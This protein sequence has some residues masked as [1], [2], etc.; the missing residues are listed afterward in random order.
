MLFS[1]YIYLYPLVFFAFSN[2]RDKYPS[3]VPW[4]INWDYIVRD[5]DVASS[6]PLS[7]S[8]RPC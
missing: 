5:S 3:I 6:V 4:K 1:R 7:P 8:G 2:I